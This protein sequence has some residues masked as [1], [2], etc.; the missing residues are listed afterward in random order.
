MESDLMEYDRDSHVWQTVNF[1]SD[2]GSNNWREAM[3]FYAHTTTE[4]TPI[5]D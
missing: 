5:H 3:K 2:L 1:W 4:R